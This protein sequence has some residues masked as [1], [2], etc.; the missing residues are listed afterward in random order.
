MMKLEKHPL[1]NTFNI[2]SLFDNFLIISILNTAE[3]LM[4]IPFVSE[5]TTAE[6]LCCQRSL[7]FLQSNLTVIY[8]S[9]TSSILSK[10]L[11]YASLFF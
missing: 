8:I 4:F 11:I 5:G 9:I 10:S 2:F 3:V 7:N 1:P 6:V